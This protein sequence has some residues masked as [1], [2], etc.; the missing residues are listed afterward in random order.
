MKSLFKVLIPFLLLSFFLPYDLPCNET[1]NSIRSIGT[2]SS[3]KLDRFSLY[4]FLHPDIVKNQNKK[5]KTIIEYRKLYYS[6]GTF[7]KA[8]TRSDYDRN[9]YII[10]ATDSGENWSRESIFKDGKRIRYT[11]EEN[12][13][14][15]S[16]M[17][18]KYDTNNNLIETYSIDS[19]WNAS[20]PFMEKIFYQYDSSN[21]LIS[22]ECYESDLFGNLLR[23]CIIEE[24]WIIEED[25]GVEKTIDIVLPPPCNTSLVNIG[26][27]LYEECCKCDFSF[28]HFCRKYL[29]DNLIEQIDYFS[30][31]R[32]N[33]IVKELKSWEFIYYD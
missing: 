12:A 17:E 18:Y 11:E 1:R 4:G 33:G 31:N 10:K 13:L 26:E 14:I 20:D 30:L 9:Q 32:P 5:I 2:D 3:G 29:D 16:L 7:S 28:D 15:V 6:D 19:R 24:D 25:V 21:N 27:N 8:V 22:E 23:P